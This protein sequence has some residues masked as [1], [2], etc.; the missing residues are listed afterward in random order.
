MVLDKIVFIQMFERYR[1]KIN[2]IYKDLHGSKVIFKNEDHAWNI[3]KNNFPS[4]W[5]I[6]TSLNFICKLNIV[7]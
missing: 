3:Y 6:G 2:I 5:E 4:K 7:A 1:G